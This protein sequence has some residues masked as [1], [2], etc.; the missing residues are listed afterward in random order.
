MAA[1]TGKLV[2]QWQAQFQGGLLTPTMNGWD[3]ALRIWN[4]ND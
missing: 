2:D 1:P 4:G 3:S